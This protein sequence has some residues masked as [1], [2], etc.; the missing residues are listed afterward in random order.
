MAKFLTLFRTRLILLIFLVVLPALALV[1]YSY[2]EQR[3]LETVRVHEGAIAMSR[4]AAAKDENY[5]KNTRQLLAALSELTFFVLAK[6]SG[7]CHTN[8][9]N[10]LKL[11]SD[12]VNLGLIESNGVVFA[13]R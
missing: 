5:V 3:R 8:F 9:S 7:F 13:S 6:D 2:G 1:L 10:L 12:Y 4:L 11:S